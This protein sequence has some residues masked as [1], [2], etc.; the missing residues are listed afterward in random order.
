MVHLVPVST[1]TTASQLSVIY[2]R[3]IVHLHSLPSSIVS[4]RDVKFMS[5][6]WRELHRLMGTKLMMSTSF[7]P[8]TDGITEQVN[9][10]I[11]QM[12]CAS[13]SPDQQDW[14]YK[15]P[16]TEFAINSS[17]NQATGMA[18]FELN[19]GYMPVVVRQ[20]PA[21]ERAPPGVRTFTMNALRN[22]GVAHDVLIAERVFQ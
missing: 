3:E 2:M 10:S 14:V 5:K 13:I 9:H 19:Y 18:P 4:D 1:T 8:Q 6:W 12:F 15:C 20:L 22:M 7:H 17:I 11:A 21:I 16:L